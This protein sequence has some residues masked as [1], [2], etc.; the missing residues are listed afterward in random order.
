MIV[1]PLTVTDRHH[2][3]G[4]ARPGPLQTTPLHG[5]GGVRTKGGGS[6][7]ITATAVRIGPGEGTIGTGEG[8][9]GAGEGTE[10]TGGGGTDEGLVIMTTGWCCCLSVCV[11][12]D[13]T[14]AIFGWG[15]REGEERRMR[16]PARWRHDRF[17][18]E[19]EDDAA[20]TAE[21]KDQKRYI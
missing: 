16:S 1:R 18:D 15:R 12:G 11:C 20:K 7:D 10:T 9:T 3:D 2:G 13:V 14:C 5:G 19:L 8:T 17:E 4:S 6:H 21:S